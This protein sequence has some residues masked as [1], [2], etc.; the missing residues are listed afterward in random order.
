MQLS[1]SG[2]MTASLWCPREDP[3]TNRGQSALRLYGGGSAIT[4]GSSGLLLDQMVSMNEHEPYRFFP[5][6]PEWPY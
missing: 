4:V 3:V 5:I 1:Y 2:N 6:E